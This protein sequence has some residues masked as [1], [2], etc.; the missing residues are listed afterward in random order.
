M[1]FWNNDYSPGLEDHMRPVR[2]T[3]SQK[4]PSSDV[5]TIDRYIDYRSKCS[6]MIY[7]KTNVT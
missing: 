7:G 3:D 6:S 2:S 4:Y 1:L 5:N